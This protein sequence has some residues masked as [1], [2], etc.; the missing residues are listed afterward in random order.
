M[1]VNVNFTVEFDED[2]YR[3]SEL[4]VEEDTNRDIREAVKGR[5]L[6]AV[7]FGLGDADVS[8]T[9]LQST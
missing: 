8:V 5:A 2:E 7:L 9:L 6:D 3:E 1:K 4:A